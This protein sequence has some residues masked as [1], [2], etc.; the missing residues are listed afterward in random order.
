MPNIGNGFVSTVVD[1]DS[2]YMAGLFCFMRHVEIFP[3]AQRCRIPTP[4]SMNMT[5]S[6]SAIESVELDIDNGVVKKIFSVSGTNATVTNS[7]Y[8][9]RNLTSLMVN[10][11]VIDNSGNDLDLNIFMKPEKDQAKSSDIAFN[12]IAS[13]HEGVATE[14]GQVNHAEEG[15]KKATVAYTYTT[16]N[17]TEPLLIPRNSVKKFTFFATFRASFQNE[18]AEPSVYAM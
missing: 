8:A 6:G 4:P 1:S 15:D 16:L 17:E 12:P 2:V 18:T 3:G 5:I 7:R 9:H 10:E 14:Q 11:Y 13:E